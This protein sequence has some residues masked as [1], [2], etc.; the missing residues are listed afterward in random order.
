[1]C[2][3]SSFQ[4]YRNQ[5]VYALDFYCES[6]RLWKDYLM[7]VYYTGFVILWTL[8][9]CTKGFN[10]SLIGRLICTVRD[11]LWYLHDHKLCI[12]MDQK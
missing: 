4:N 9:S 3:K 5:L 11:S 8:T 7:S 12:V 6:W 1:M 10:T 2:R